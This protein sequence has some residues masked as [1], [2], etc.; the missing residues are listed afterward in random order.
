MVKHIKKITKYFEYRWA[1]SNSHRYTKWLKNKGCKVGERVSWHGLPDIYID[2]T[3]PSLVEIGNDVCFTRGCTILTHGADWHVLRNL[4]GEVF[5]SSGKVKV[6]NNVFLGTATM[7]L[8]GVSIGDNCIIGA[9]SLVNKD[10]PS[11]SVAAGNPARI[12]CSIKDYYN[13]RKV[14]YIDEAKAYALSIRENL[15][16]NPIPADF[17]EE[18]PLFHN[19]GL[20][21]NLSRLSI[22]H[23]LGTSYEHYLKTH[24][25]HYD[26]F[27]SFL[28]DAGI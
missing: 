5:A 23:Q 15:G 3:R 10:I 1:T 6:G 19:V 22:R 18:F 17:W 11:D 24:Q 13:K 26:S 14:E 20:S 9:C 12:I 8:K 21:L 25:P 4:Y 7:I 2:T 27:E 16:R 28:K